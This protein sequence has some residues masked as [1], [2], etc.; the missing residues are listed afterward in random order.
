[1]ADDPDIALALF[2][3]VATLV[4]SSPNLPIDY[5]EPVT[6]F[7][8]PADGKY[9]SAQVFFNRPA[10]EG[11]TRGKISQGLLQINVVWPKNKGVVDPLRIAKV[12]IA[13]FPK[14][15]QLAS[16]VKISG[17]PWAGSP[18]SAP[19]EVVIPVTIPWSA[20]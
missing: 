10:Y 1:M 13:H 15:L 9:L 14:A 4:V 20:V 11:L 8:P 12:V 7:V 16:G 18:I 19:S 6:E 17:Q 5:P 3:R 2:A